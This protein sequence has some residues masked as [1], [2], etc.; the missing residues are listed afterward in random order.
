MTSFLLFFGALNAL[1]PVVMLSTTDSLSNYSSH[2][3]VIM[4]NMFVC[5]VCLIFIALCMILS[6]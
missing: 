2:Q 1:T 5:G 6:A 3:R 4:R